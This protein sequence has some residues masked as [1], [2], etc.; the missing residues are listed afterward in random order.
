VNGVPADRTMIDVLF[1]TLQQVEPARPVA[2]TLQD[3][4]SSVLDT[5]GVVV[6]L[7]AGDD[8][9]REFIAGGNPGKTQAYFKIP[10]ESECYIMT[11]PGYRVYASGIF[12]LDENGW[13]DRLVFNFNWR[14][15]QSLKATHPSS[16]Q[17]DFEVAMGKEYYEVKGVAVVDTTKL[18][19]FLDAVSLLTVDQYVKSETVEGYDS[20]IRTKPLLDL[21]IS[22]VSGK[23][24]TLILYEGGSP[25]AVLGIIEGVQPAF[26]DK[27]KVSGILKSRSW[28][29]KH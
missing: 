12:E 8:L 7:F 4:V 5:Q 1:A 2:E 28:F 21:Q 23:T 6:S 9:Q 13:R 29:V 27:R 15:F 3:S 24:Y 10:G 16:P 20:L 11:I 19:D 25:Q 18:N 26:F 14:N 22:D 17:H